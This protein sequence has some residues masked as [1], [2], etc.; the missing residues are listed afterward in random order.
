MKRF[1]V[2][3]CTALSALAVAG[4]NEAKAQYGVGP[5]RIILPFSPGGAIDAIARMVAE[6]ITLSTG[7]SAVVENVTG[8]SGHIG[9]RIVRD[10]KPDGSVLL[11]N[12]ASPMI[13]HEHFFGDKLT[14]NPFTD[15]APIT[16]A[17]TSDY[18]LAVAKNV[19]ATNVK[20][21]TAWLKADPKRASYGTPGAGAL[22]HFLGLEFGRIIGVEMEHV[23]YRGSPPALNDLAAGQLPIA[24]LTTSEFTQHH[25]AGSI[26][27]I[28]TF[29]DGPSPFVAGVPTLKEQGVNLEALG[30][31]AFYAP[32]KTPS[33]IIAKINKLI[34]DMVRE[35]AVQKRFLEMGIQARGSTP[36]ELGR[37]QRRDTDFWGPIVKASGFRPDL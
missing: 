30:W 19:P 21:L 4:L 27:I 29:T 23:P 18:A 25:A 33:D 28:G 20:E 34:V 11:I 17:A 31:Y 16:M 12:P 6:R 7:K 10:A 35:P 26:R 8:A 3:V 36:E 32:G 13:L 9:M 15:F 37:Q 24:A 14:F 22:T 5:V 1:I 2:A